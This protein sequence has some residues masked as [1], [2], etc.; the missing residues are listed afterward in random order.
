MAA[1]TAPFDPKTSAVAAL[2][3]TLAEPSPRVL[4]GTAAIPGFFK[5]QGVAAK[6]AAEFCLKEQW[7]EET[8]EKVG[9][10]AK[11]KSLYRLT[12]QG[13]EAVLQNSPPLAVLQSLD[14]GLR[15]QQQ[16]LEG[17]L[18]AVQQLTDQAANRRLEQMLRTAVEKLSPP[19]VQETLKRLADSGRR[20]MGTSQA[21]QEEI[22][23]RAS[24][25]DSSHPLSLPELFHDLRK[26]WPDLD[27]GQFHDGIRALRDAGRIRLQPFTRAYAEIAGRREAIFLDG[28]VMYYVR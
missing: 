7:L 19:D 14:A 28:E 26:T 3:S 8:G 10:G 18:A 2:A 11:A 22:V 1:R 5:G 13:V 16:L 12:P 20:P 27:L 24:R 17:V 25:A 4:F 21:W 23:R 6:K 15:S 9:K